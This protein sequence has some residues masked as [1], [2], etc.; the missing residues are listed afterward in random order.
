ME[1][2]KIQNEYH[3]QLCEIIRKYCNDEETSKSCF[4]SMK[5]ASFDTDNGC[6]LYNNTPDMEILKLDQLSKVFN[7]KRGFGCPPSAVD[8]AFINYQ[9]EWFLIEFKNSNFY[10]QS[11]EN[12]DLSHKRE[13][14]SVGSSRKKMLSSLW[15]LFYIYSISEQPLENITRFSREHVT[16]IAVYKR[17]KNLQIAMP[18]HQAEVM[19]KHFTPKEYAPYIGYYFKDA[20]VITEQELRSFIAKFE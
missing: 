12:K 10:R 11:S 15:L 18:I 19:N 9:N 1:Q 2:K 14:K 4:A 8:S 7:S 5:D 16:Y 17:D 13:D 6:Y 20:Y 3:L